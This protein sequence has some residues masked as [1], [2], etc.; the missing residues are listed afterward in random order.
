MSALPD[1]IFRYPFSFSI[2]WRREEPQPTPGDV[3]RWSRR[4]SIFFE[5]RLLQPQ[6]TAAM[7]RAIMTIAQSR[8]HIP[9]AML[10]RILAEADPVVTSN[11]DR[12]RFEGFSSC[13][14]AY[15]RVDLLSAAFEGTPYFL[16]S[17]EKQPL[18]AG[19][20]SPGTKNL[21]SPFLREEPARCAAG[22]RCE[23][24]PRLAN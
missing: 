15:V 3:P 1:Q 23:V 6:Q 10:G 24:Q 7:L 20:Q 18:S 16:T 9:A 19:T 14:G 21:L 22:S 4:Q 8:F 11:D 17:T 13:C 12:L 2:V 5:G